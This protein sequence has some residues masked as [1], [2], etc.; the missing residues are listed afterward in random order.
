MVV[1]ARCARL[2]SPLGAE[3]EKRVAGSEAASEVEQE[4]LI[5]GSEPCVEV[6]VERFG[7]LPPLPLLDGEHVRLGGLRR[8]GE[9][10]AG[11]RVDPGAVPLRGRRRDAR[12]GRGSDD[13]ADRGGGGLSAGLLVGLLPGV[14]QSLGLVEER[15]EFAGLAFADLGTHGSQRG[16]Y[17]RVLDQ[18]VHVARRETPPLLAVHLEGGARGA[19]EALVPDGDEQAAGPIEEALPLGLDGRLV[20]SKRRGL[21]QRQGGHAFTASM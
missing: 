8:V 3:R 2:G 10:L 5:G 1:A 21:R 12:D 16:A 4:P 7:L 11:A 20:L 19:V 9:H 6:G 18:A 17:L 14:A 15:G 13:G